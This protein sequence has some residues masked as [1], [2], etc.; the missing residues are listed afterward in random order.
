MARVWA[1]S[2]VRCDA[3]V[4][5]VLVHEPQFLPWFFPLAY[6]RHSRDITKSFVSCCFHHHCRRSS[7]FLGETEKDRETGK[8][9]EEGRDDAGEGKFEYVT[10]NEK[11]S[12]QV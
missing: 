4:V 7:R 5:A 1:L 2:A 6:A 10:A 9:E 12:S 11:G 3:T 8:D